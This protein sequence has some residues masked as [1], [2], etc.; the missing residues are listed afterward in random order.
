[1]S[2]ISKRIY[3]SFIRAPEN[4]ALSINRREHSYRDIL[5]DVQALHDT[6]GDTR[7]ERLAILGDRTRTAYAGV[8]Y[9]ILKAKTFVP[10][11][12]LFPA[13]QNGTIISLSESTVILFD[14]SSWKHIAP[15]VA[16][17]ASPLIFVSIDYGETPASDIES[18]HEKLKGTKHRFYIARSSVND[19]PASLAE[20]D[21]NQ[22][23]YI[24][25]TSGT[26]G[27]PKGVPITHGNAGHYFSSI[28]T[29]AD[30]SPT[31]RFSQFFD[32]TF[33]L[34]I[35][36]I[37]LTWMA[38]GCLCVPTRLDLVALRKFIERERITIWFSV[39]SAAAMMSQIGQLRPGLYPAIRYSFF[40][41]EA[42]PTSIASAWQA[43]AP[44]SRIINLYGPTEATIAF[45]AYEFSANRSAESYTNGI[46]PLGR[47]F[48][49]NLACIT[50]DSGSPINEGEQ[51][52]LCLSGPQLTAGYL[53]NP[54][55]NAE[56]FFLQ[57]STDGKDIR[58]Y[59]TGDRAVFNNDFGYVYYGRA[60]S[61]VK[62][63]G[64]RVEILEIESVL[65]EVCELDQ[66]AAVPWP[67]SDGLAQGVIAFVVKPDISPD[68]IIKRCKERLAF[69]KV[70][71]AVHILDRMPLNSNGKTDRNALKKMLEAKT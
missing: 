71:S 42:L 5:R 54:Q 18:F 70:P 57:R 7:F 10:I 33:D 55:Q 8:A 50:D 9:A 46:V 30:F 41:G 47:P 25:F 53:N 4:P 60:D 19:T 20:T 14:L 52:E 34:S 11:N 13:V 65:R 2:Q 64:Y 68:E 27:V 28:L 24:M 43:A 66:I 32:L 40:C 16:E 49:D 56:R 29:L 22:F 37:L 3:E 38:G 44:N 67:I 35:H 62:I 69:Y 31:D 58:W 15:L 51:G 36:D 59:R 12:P 48:G 6:L 45:T 26:T 63:L 1:M 21:E 61:Q 39:P 17:F 23:L